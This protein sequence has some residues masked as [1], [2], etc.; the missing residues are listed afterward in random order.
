MKGYNILAAPIRWLPKHLRKPSVHQTIKQSMIRP[1][2]TRL[3][4]HNWN[5]YLFNWVRLQCFIDTKGGFGQLHLAC[6]LGP[7]F[8]TIARRNP[9][10]CQVLH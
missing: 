8:D 9:L 7:M 5:I 10:L 1:S 6:S 2:D 3:S 4:C